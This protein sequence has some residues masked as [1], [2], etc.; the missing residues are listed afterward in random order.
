MAR[1]VARAV[2]RKGASGIQLCSGVLQQFDN[3]QMLGA[4][5]FALPASDTVGSFAVALSD[6]SA[7]ES[8]GMEMIAVQV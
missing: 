5:A 7:V 2:F 1:A 6:Q 3:R 8:A 4:Y